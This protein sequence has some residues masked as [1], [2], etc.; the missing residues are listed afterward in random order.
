MP[1]PADRVR[2]LATFDAFMTPRAPPILIPTRGSSLEDTNTTVGYSNSGGGL[3]ASALLQGMNES[4]VEMKEAKKEEQRATT[5]K[6]DKKS[7]KKKSKK[8]G[9]K[10]AD[11]TT[12]VKDSSNAKIDE[13]G[14]ASGSL[15]KSD[16]KIERK[17]K[18]SNISAA[19]EDMH[20]STS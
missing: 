9:K 18:E 7:K 11:D 15:G 19:N 2:L 8:D 14:K 4:E 10:V 20:N 3:T 16:A 17:P 12:K 6:S 13:N 1:I 5:T